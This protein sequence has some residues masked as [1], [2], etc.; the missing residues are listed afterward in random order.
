MAAEP[1]EMEAAGTYKFVLSSADEEHD[2]IRLRLGTTVLCRHRSVADTH[3]KSNAD[4]DTTYIGLSDCGVDNNHLQYLSRKHVKITCRANG[5]HTVTAL[6][7]K[8]VGGEA[9]SRCP[10]KPPTTTPWPPPPPSPLPPRP[11]PLPPPP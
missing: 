4:P 1:S 3:N 5:A 2:S 11:S 7:T 10:A 9:Q 8:Q 6:T